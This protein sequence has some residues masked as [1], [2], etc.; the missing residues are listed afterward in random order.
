M[1]DGSILEVVKAKPIRTGLNA[2]RD[3][4]SL[5]CQD[6]GVPK[7]LESLDRIDNEGKPAVLLMSSV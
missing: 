1:S 3:S 4:F 7:H 2:F 5:V 6:F